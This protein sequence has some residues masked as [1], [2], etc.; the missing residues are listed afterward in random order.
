M[1]LT[2]SD[3]AVL[4]LIASRML[5]TKNELVKSFGGTN[6]TIGSLKT[7]LDKRYIAVVSPLGSSSY[8]ITQEGERFL[9]SLEGNIQK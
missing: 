5:V 6:G 8:V 1:D 9:R 3:I 2:E 7:L 4:K